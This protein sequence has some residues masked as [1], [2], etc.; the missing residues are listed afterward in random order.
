MRGPLPRIGR[1]YDLLRQA[2]IPSTTAG[3]RSRTLNAE[4]QRKAADELKE[5]V[6]ATNEAI[7]LLDQGQV[8]SKAYALVYML[9]RR[10]GYTVRKMGQA[11]EPYPQDRD[12]AEEVIDAAIW[13]AS[14]K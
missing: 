13:E 2:G 14:A 10:L 6:A 12:W 11:S 7:R 3:T 8:D 1:T 4:R 5:F 9:R